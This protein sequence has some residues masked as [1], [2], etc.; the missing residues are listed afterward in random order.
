MKTGWLFVLLTLAASAWADG[1]SLGIKVNAR[2]ANKKDDLKVDG[3]TVQEVIDEDSPIKSGDVIVDIDREKMSSANDL[4][5][6]EAEANPDKTYKVNL[7]RQEKG[8]WRK[9]VVSVKVRQREEKEEEVFRFRKAKPEFNKPKMTNEEILAAQEKL[10]GRYIRTAE[11]MLRIQADTGTVYLPAVGE[12][13]YYQFLTHRFK[14]NGSKEVQEDKAGFYRIA[15]GKA[16]E[17]VITS[18][19]E[20]LM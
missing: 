2:P 16:A 11:G 14:A 17:I 10:A 9:R 19:G 1:Q 4:K 15:D 7:Y 12:K 13:T 3:I 20:N 18:N 8:K 5:K 6:W